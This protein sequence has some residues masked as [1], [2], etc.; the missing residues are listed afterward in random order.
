MKVIIQQL[1]EKYNLPPDGFVYLDSISYQEAEAG[2]SS[3]AITND[4]ETIALISSR[5]DNKTGALRLLDSSMEKYLK[6][7]KSPDKQYCGSLRKLEHEEFLSAR[8]NEFGLLSL[9]GLQH[10]I[11]DYLLSS[12]STG[13]RT[14]EHLHRKRLDIEPYL[15]KEKKEIVHD[16]PDNKSEQKSSASN[17]WNLLFEESN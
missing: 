15:L 12:S 14:W 17:T 6:K 13:I 7:L 10:R 3:D 2:I 9:I 11:S 1:I 16:E 8:E 4:L 5:Y